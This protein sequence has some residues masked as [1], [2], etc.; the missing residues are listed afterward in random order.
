MENDVQGK[1]VLATGGGSGVGE[2]TAYAF[3][4]TGCSVACLDLSHDGTER[5]NRAF[6]SRGDSVALQCNC[7]MLT[8]CLRRWP[9]LWIR[10]D[11][12]RGRLCDLC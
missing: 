2:A 6:V 4:R 9:G 8:P 11:R 10:P 7:A 1:V 5:V 12:S 3:A